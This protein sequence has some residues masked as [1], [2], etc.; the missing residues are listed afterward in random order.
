DGPPLRFMEVCGTHT[1]NIFQY[2]IR[3]ILPRQI[4]LISGP[5]CPV[6]VT[7]SQYIDYAAQLSLTEHSVLCTFGDM[8]RVPG[9]STSL[10]KT[11]A[12]GG[13]VKIMYAPVDVI[14]WA[15]R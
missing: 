1:H 6:C 12:Q 9:I 11:K 10:M 15:E 3:D 4:A 5:G 7:P 8:V 13:N 2:G 14:E